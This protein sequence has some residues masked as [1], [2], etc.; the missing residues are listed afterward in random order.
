MTPWVRHLLGGDVDAVWC[1]HPG[2]FP[3]AVASAADNARIGD[4]GG[5]Q[6]F[7]AEKSAAAKDPG[8]E[9]SGVDSAPLL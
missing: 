3:A 1:R 6:M 8:H 4:A 9:G 2:D 5:G 7:T